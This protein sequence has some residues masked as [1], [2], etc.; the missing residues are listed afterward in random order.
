M[1]LFKKKNIYVLMHKDIPVCTGE[2]DISKHEFSKIT[3]IHNS[4]HLPIGVIEQGKLSL[5]ALN[6]W[7]RWRGIPAYRVGLVQ[8]SER[9]EISDPTELL[10][11]EYALSVSDTYWIKEDH[12][13]VSWNEINFFHRS[14]DQQG[15]GQAMFSTMSGHPDGSAR[16]TPNNTLCGYHRKAWFKR[17]DGLYLLKG[18]SPF[19]QLEPVNEWLAGQIA[20]RLGLHAI[21]YEV[22]LYENNLVSVC[23]CIT[24]E[25]TD[26]VTAGDVLLTGNPPQD[27]FQL[28]YYIS[29]LEEHGIHDAKKCLSDMLVLDFLLMNTDRHNQN[30]GILV[31]ANTMEWK[32]VA[33]IF[34]TGTGLGCLDGDEEVLAHEHY[35]D[36]KLFNS[37]N[38][39]HDLLLQYIDL[40][41]YDFSKLDGLPRQYGEKLLQFQPVSQISNNRINDSYKLFYKRV[42]RIQKAAGI[43][44]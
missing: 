43:T 32:G 22:E 36:C 23:K 11:K 3:K 13:E 39:S 33:P 16:H 38:F 19:Y 27:K 14:Y 10:D 21:P 17:E 9:L 34:D 4:E 7:Y 1:P 15:F 42:L 35:N 30:H 12:D 5:K 8:L 29:L 28:S 40:N 37:R 18:G 26:L 25:N 31:D 41:A 20:I 2:Y 44:R 6:H 24:D